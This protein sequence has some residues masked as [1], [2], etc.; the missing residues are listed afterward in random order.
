LSQAI[1]S[2]VVADVP[3]G[4]F[5]SG[6]V[7]SSVV[8]A[9]MKDSGVAPLHTFSVGVDDAVM[10]ESALAKH[11]AKTLGSHHHETRLTAKALDEWP[12]II[13]YLGEPLAD[14]SIMPS[15]AV[16]DL[17]SAHV[18]VVL[19]GDG[20]D[21]VFLGYPKYQ[22]LMAGELVASWPPAVRKFLG[23][24]LF[25]G[26]RLEKIFP[27]N[28]NLAKK[29]YINWTGHFSL[30]ELHTCLHPKVL[31]EVD[32]EGRAAMFA[33]FFSN[34]EHVVDAAAAWDFEHYLGSILLHKMDM[35]SM[36]YGL[37]ARS[38]FLDHRL[39]EF[40][41]SLPVDMKLNFFSRKRILRH[42]RETRLG[43]ELFQRKKRG[44]SVPLRAWLQGR[45]MQQTRWVDS[46]LLRSPETKASLTA[47]QQLNLW[48][49]DVWSQTQT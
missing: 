28:G 14:A 38:P 18:K 16:A 1:T 40:V 12:H 41:F 46:V 31:K 47:T 33:Q 45:G 6:G 15:L 43:P 13:E 17:A 2:Q 48:A 7:D 36:R 24:V 42:A 37:E 49:I 9:G 22:A 30:E 10:D 26:T 11:F 44:F 34:H 4:C 29:A 23:G 8:A 39:I 35:A 27:S 3:V 32:L 20:G 21:E 19:N 5:L 25:R